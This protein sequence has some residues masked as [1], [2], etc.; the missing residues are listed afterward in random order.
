MQVEEACSLHEK[1]GIYV[2]VQEN[3][4]IAFVTCHYC[5]SMKIKLHSFRNNVETL[6]MQ[7]L[8]GNGHILNCRQ[9]RIPQ[10][11]TFNRKRL[12]DFTNV[13]MASFCLGYRPSEQ[14]ES[15]IHEMNL[16]QQFDMSKD[17]GFYPDM[18]KRNLYLISEP[19]VPILSVV[20]S[21]RS[22]NC[23]HVTQSKLYPLAR[24]CCLRCMSIPNTREFKSLLGMVIEGPNK[25]RLLLLQ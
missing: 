11:C 21:F 23:I 15:Y 5:P 13:Y 24:H 25:N 17:F 8:N 1:D 19:T 3:N 9:S 6:L 14:D 20:G 18:S 22:D 10:F 16:M 4:R 2:D 7:H 12:E